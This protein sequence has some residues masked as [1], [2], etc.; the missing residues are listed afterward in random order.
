M[1]RGQWQW[2]VGSGQFVTLEPIRSREKY[3]KHFSVIK[4]RC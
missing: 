4:L 3:I 1:V 2:A